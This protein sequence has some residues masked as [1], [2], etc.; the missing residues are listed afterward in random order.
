[1]KRTSLLLSTLV[2]AVGSMAQ[3]GIRLTLEEA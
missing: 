2:L 3:S 1:M